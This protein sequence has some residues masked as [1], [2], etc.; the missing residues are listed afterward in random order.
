MNTQ[1]VN[2][3]TKEPSK[4]W[5]VKARTSKFYQSINHSYR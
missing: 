4:R 2:T 3:A 1:Y 5:G